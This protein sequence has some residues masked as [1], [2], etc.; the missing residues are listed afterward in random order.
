MLWPEYQAPDMIFDVADSRLCSVRRDRRCRGPIRGTLVLAALGAGLGLLAC[1]G[2]G[3][4]GT[5]PTSPAAPPP[6]QP[7]TMAAL[8]NESL[9][10][11][12]VGLFSP[13]TN[14]AGS[15]I[16]VVGS[17][18]D[19]IRSDN[20]FRIEPVMPGEHVISVVGT[21]H[22]NRHLRVE[23]LAGGPNEIPDLDLAEDTLFNLPAFDEIYREDG[24]RGTARFLKR[25]R[26]LIDQKDFDGLP[27]ATGDQLISEIK[28]A[29]T[30]PIRQAIGPL[31]AG[32]QVI[33][34]ASIQDYTS[35]CDLPDNEVN[36]QAERELRSSE[37]E[38]LLGQAW[39][40]WFPEHNA[41]RGGIL[42]LDDQAD[43]GTI[44]HELVHLLGGA[45]H[46]EK[47]PGSSVISVPR[48]VAALSTM[49]EQHLQFLYK[50]P[51]GLETPDDARRL[52]PSG[53]TQLSGGA[54]MEV[55]CHIFPD[56]RAQIERAPYG[57][58]IR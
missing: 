13:A 21:G 27:G 42:T 26:F 31:F 41:V 16:K 55:R 15:R 46:L 30:G 47:S 7:P 45:A 53:L 14:F 49:D 24:E 8:T 9:F 29:T 44:L 2:G 28:M 51:A 57:G 1:G 37:G 12:V 35:P 36:W 10:G 54:G 39:W 11:Q 33:T 50:R 32:V 43:T 17:G 5:S 20:S 52:D 23:M 6:G 25:P 22:L 56:G 40:C 38:L 4:G 34:R 19:T 3:G 48:S 58:F 18:V